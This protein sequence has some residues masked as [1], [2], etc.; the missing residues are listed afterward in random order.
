[1]DI[2]KSGGAAVGATAKSVSEVE[3]YIGKPEVVKRLGMSLRT[4][5]DW[6][7]RGLLPYYKLGHSVLFKWSE[8]ES[9]LAQ[10]CRVCRRF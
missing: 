7:K 6:M 10:T 9:H 5:D 4:V 2:Q 1:M 3:P 8:I